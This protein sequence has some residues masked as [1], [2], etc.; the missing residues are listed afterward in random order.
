MGWKPETRVLVPPEAQ[1]GSLWPLPALG[2][3]ASLQP[4]LRG[5]VAAGF[6][7]LLF[8]DRGGRVRTH[9]TLRMILS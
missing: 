5:H 4:L 7:C 6:P 8:Q 9:L 3:H 2:S 1:G